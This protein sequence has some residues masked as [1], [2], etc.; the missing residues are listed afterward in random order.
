MSLR[1]W[2]CGGEDELIASQPASQLAWAVICFC[3]VSL[4]NTCIHFVGFI[5]YS[6]FSSFVLFLSWFL[7][8]DY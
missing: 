5:L 2:G 3:F 6:Y 1:V 8:G 4:I 7:F